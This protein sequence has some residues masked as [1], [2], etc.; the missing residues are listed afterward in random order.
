MFRSLIAFSGVLMLGVFGSALAQETAHGTHHPDTAQ[1]DTAPPGGPMV[2]GRMA[3]N[4]K[5]MMAASPA[6]RALHQTM[7]ENMTDGMASIRGDA[8]QTGTG[9]V[10][11]LTK[12]YVN[13]MDAMHGPMFDGIM[14]DDPDVAFVAGMIPH[15]EGAIAMAE[16]VLRFGD[17]PQTSA[18]AEEIIEAQEGEI[19]EMKAWLLERGTSATEAS[20]SAYTANEGANT[21]SV[22]DLGTGAVQTVPIPV[23]PHNVDLSPSGDHLLAVGDPASD[24]AHETEDQE[25]ASADVAGLL[26]VLDPRQITQAP[27]VI[28]VGAHP[29]H[30]VA[31]DKGVAYVSLAGGNEVAV[32]GLEDGAVL[33][34]IET[35]AYPHGLRLS[36]DKTELYVANVED[37]SVS[38][39]DTASHIEITRIPVGAAP[40]QVGFAPSGDRVY[41]SL[42][43]ENSVAVIDTGAR[44]VVRK[45]EV[46]PDPIQVMVTPDGKYVYVAN[47]GSDEEPNDTVSVIEAAT[48]EVVKTIVTGP[49]AHGVA[50]SADGAFVFVTNIADDTVSVIEV[51]TQTVVDTI[52]VDD[53]PNGI[54]HGTL[55]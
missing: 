25:H 18:W 52:R 15:H 35:G 50:V 42:R 47:Q 43:D 9:D 17:D 31:D 32:V 12:A 34:R 37:G 6:A 40:V 51:A 1:E 22:I 5:D 14:A 8:S 21:I 38:V 4:C 41:V 39:I 48:G 27:E 16:I 30:V 19:A 10:P 24:H 44:E 45:I 55:N 11:K 3:D 20:G 26:V 2:A 29:A 7:H 54:V 33:E 13:A 28:E 46:G 23:A 36:P 49:G 53:R